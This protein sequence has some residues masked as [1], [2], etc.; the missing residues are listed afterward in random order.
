MSESITRK[1]MLYKSKV[2]YMSGEGVYTMNHVLGCSHGCMYPCY[3]SEAAI[4]RNQVEDYDDWC[5]PRIVSNTLQLLECELATKRKEPIE[6]VHLCF[7]TD[8]FM[9]GR[10]D[11]CE[12]TLACIDLLNKSDIPVTVLTKGGYPL[13]YMNVLEGHPDN[14]YGVTLASLNEG[15]CYEWE[16]YAD[17]PMHRLWTLEELHKAGMHTWVSMEPFPACTKRTLDAIYGANDPEWEPWSTGGLDGMPDDEYSAL[18]E[19]LGAA[20]FVERLVFGRWNYNLFM[21]TDQED[22]AG[23]YKGAAAIVRRFCDAQSIECIIKKGT[24]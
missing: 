6:R 23:W 10:K 24:E 19:C 16:P 5:Q 11:V 17:E 22:V 14:E 15:F 21:P 3:A 2:E 1:R 7:T 12:L 8:P 9:Y 4:R 13:G 18:R 20:A